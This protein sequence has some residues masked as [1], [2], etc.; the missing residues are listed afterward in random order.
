MTYCLGWRTGTEA[1]I[2]ADSAVTSI[3]PLGENE[4]TSFGEANINESGVSVEEGAVKVVRV[5]DYALGFSG[6]AAAA[7][8]FLAVFERLIEF[9]RDL[10]D[11]L[12]SAT[13][14]HLW[15]RS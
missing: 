13:L 6:D 14:K 11:A 3:F 12:A 1:I 8:E 5:G 4:S 2:V 10:R 15:I 7:G 9:G